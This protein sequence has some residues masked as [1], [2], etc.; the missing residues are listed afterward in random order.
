[1]TASHVLPVSLFKSRSMTISLL[2]L[3]MLCPLGVA[4]YL[5]KQDRPLQLGLSHHGTLISPMINIENMNFYN[6]K[7]QQEVKGKVLFGKWS[8]VYVGPKYCQQ[9]CYSTL[10]NLRQIRTALGKNSHR[11]Q[12]IFIA[13]PSCPLSVCE[14][15][16]GEIYPDMLRVKILS[17][18]LDKLVGA[19][20]NI[21]ERD[22]VG[23]LYLID[24]IGNIMMRYSVENE[25]RGILS[26][27]KRLLKIS[28]IG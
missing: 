10:Y 27:I 11:L 26:D 4:W 15:Y 9:T 18:E 21:P 12:R 17:P 3:I 22:L 6:L 2:L 1:M 23:E 16:L 14:I 19:I 7:T 13:H 24:P 20:G 28:K 8:L 25:P 5:V